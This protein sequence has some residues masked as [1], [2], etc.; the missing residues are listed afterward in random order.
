[1]TN[2]RVYFFYVITRDH[3]LLFFTRIIEAQVSPLL[4]PNP[5]QYSI[6]IMSISSS[7]CVKTDTSLMIRAYPWMNGVTLKQMR[8][9]YLKDV[10]ANS[11]HNQDLV[12]MA[13]VSYIHITYDI[14]YYLLV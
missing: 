11:N 1:M 13:L 10:L 9:E 7:N 2:N 8:Q 6:S 14:Y 4:C 5:L 12:S 3:N